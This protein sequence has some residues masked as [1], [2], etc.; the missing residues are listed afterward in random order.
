[1]VLYS[2]CMFYMPGRM[3][4]QPCVFVRVNHPKETGSSEIFKDEDYAK[5]AENVAKGE[6]VTSK[7]EP[8]CRFPVPY[9]PRPG[10]EIIM[11]IP[12]GMVDW[13]I[14]SKC[15]KDWYSHIDSDSDSEVE[16]HCPSKWKLKGRSP[17]WKHAKSSDS[18]K[19]QF[20]KD[21]RKYL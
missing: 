15:Y 21:A 6:N 4:S 17:G 10:R 12:L 7:V 3:F 13:V 9:F 1:M 14:Y 20:P 16:S 18:T 8:L 2:G 11:P 5:N 19:F